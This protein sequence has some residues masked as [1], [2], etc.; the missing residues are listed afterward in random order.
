MAR[1][2]AELTGILVACAHRIVGCSLF[3]GRQPRRSLA[4]I[5]LAGDHIGDQ[6]GAVLAQEGD[7]TLVAVD[8]RIQRLKPL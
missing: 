3:V 2:S 8:H 4:H 5:E 1:K 6:A 7:L